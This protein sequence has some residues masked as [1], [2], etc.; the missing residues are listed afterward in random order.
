MENFTLRTDD[1]DCWFLTKSLE[2]VKLIS[3]TPNTQLNGRKVK[4]FRDFYSKPLKSSFLHIFESDSIMDTEKIY[5]INDIKSKVFCVKRNQST[6]V[7]FPLLHT[8]H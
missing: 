6:S 2:I 8:F 5:S 7:F 4:A 1:S 3:I